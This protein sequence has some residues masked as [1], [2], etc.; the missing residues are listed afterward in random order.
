MPQHNFFSEYGLQIKLVKLVMNE[1]N[2]ISIKKAEKITNQWLLL[3][4]FSDLDMH[5]PLTLI[6]SGN[7]RMNGTRSLHLETHIA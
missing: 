6:H 7:S 5:N 2:S 4:K 3:F 1:K